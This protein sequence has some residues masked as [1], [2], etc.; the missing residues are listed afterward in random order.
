MARRYTLCFRDEFQKAVTIGGF[1]VDN[2]IEAFAEAQGVMRK[3]IVEIW[4]GSRQVGA[5]KTSPPMKI[6]I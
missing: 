3:Q 5:I 1:E 6:Y 4:E 2:D